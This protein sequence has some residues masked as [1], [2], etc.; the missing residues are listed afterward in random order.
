MPVEH[1][2]QALPE[3]PDYI[4]LQKGLL[5]PETAILSARPDI[6]VISDGF[7]DFD[8]TAAVVALCDLVISVDSVIAHLA[9]AMGKPTWVLLAQRSEWRWMKARSDTPWYPTVRLFRQAV[10]GEWSTVVDAVRG[11]LAGFIPV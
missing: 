7:E 1:I 3:G 6:R 11:E 8:D 4:C 9:G 5:P 2:V 10:Q